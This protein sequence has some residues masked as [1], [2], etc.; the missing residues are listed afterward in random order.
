MANRYD[1]KDTSKI[2]T[3]DKF[4]GLNQ[5]NS[6]GETTIQLE[7]SPDMLNFKITNQFKLQKREGYRSI[8]K[9]DEKLSKSPIQG[10]YYAKLGD[11]FHFVL[12]QGGKLREY[13]FDSK[14]LSEIGDITDL[15]CSF[16]VMNDILYILNGQDYKQYDGSTLKDVEGYIPTIITGMNPTT[17]GGTT[18]DQ[19]NSLTGKR[20]VEYTSDGSIKI[21][22]LPEVDLKEINE[23]RINN[24]PTQ[25]YSVNLLT[26]VITFNSAPPKGTNNVE[27][28]YET[29]TNN[30]EWVEKCTH[31]ML[32]GGNN[33]TRVFIWGNPD[34]KNARIRSGLY[35]P[36]YFPLDNYDLIGSDETAITDIVRQNDRMIIFKENS[37]FYSYYQQQ[38]IKDI[39]TAVFPVYNLNSVIGNVASGQVQILNENPFTL[40]HGVH[41]WV[42]TQIRDERNVKYM[43]NKVKPTLDV[44]DLKNA[45]T[46][47]YQAEKEYFIC[48]G[49]DIWV[50]NYDIKVWYKY[51][52]IPA[53]YFIYINGSLYFGTNEGDINKFDYE[54]TGDNLQPIN[55]HWKSGFTNL[56]IETNVK[57]L[58]ETWLTLKPE[59]KSRIFFSWRTNKK[60]QNNKYEANYSFAN[61][62]DVDFANWS[63]ETNY[64]PQPF[65]FKTKAKKFAYI[66]FILEDSS[67]TH[68]STI[69]E[70]NIRVRTGSKLK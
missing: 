51:N 64:N 67:E 14:S 28:T 61:F 32:F 52:N 38:T 11:K 21:Y 55:V 30:R 36:N 69:L 19:I 49:S 29:K 68:H 42:A 8:I 41:Q 54:Y 53:T 37:S 59:T 45:I 25:A 60:S 18:L 62:D 4:T 27:I 70:I 26:G 7:E 9:T 57:Y 1:F 17:K 40:Y 23:I 65:R 6:G 43:S 48:V 50:Y 13:D 47:D 33:D 24:T 39:I 16:F 3:I 58:A 66:Q 10:M 31:A 46:F 12:S 2:I 63:F 56:G 44:A 20:K 15:K 22:N 34:A 35:K 5:D